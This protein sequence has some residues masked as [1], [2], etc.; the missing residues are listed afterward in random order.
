M[1]YIVAPINSPFKIQIFCRPRKILNARLTKSYSLV[2]IKLSVFFLIVVV[3][4]GSNELQDQKSRVQSWSV[5]FWLLSGTQRTFIEAKVELRP[6]NVPKSFDKT[7][8]TSS[9]LRDS[10]EVE[11]NFIY[12][13]FINALSINWKQKY[14]LAC[15][16]FLSEQVYFFPFPTIETITGSLFS[17]GSDLDT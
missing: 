1:Q 8:A 10:L 3:P 7:V 14:I 12:V 15:V 13:I 11:L 5:L 4:K 2:P 17:I 6:E 9:Q 16:L